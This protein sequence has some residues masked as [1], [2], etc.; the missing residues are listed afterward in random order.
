MLLVI[1][2]IN[3]SAEN[4]QYDWLKLTNIFPDFITVARYKEG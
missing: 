3:I 1:L 4:D 2:F